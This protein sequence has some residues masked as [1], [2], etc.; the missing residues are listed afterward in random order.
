[1]EK[2]RSGLI[3][4]AGQTTDCEFKV[5]IQF[6]L[7]ISKC[8]DENTFKLT[9][10]V[11]IRDPNLSHWKGNILRNLFSWKEFFKE[12]FLKTFNLASTATFVN[13]KVF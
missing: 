7:D 5:F 3:N 2:C 10:T 4:A 8:F 12:N 9:E 1:M 6:I 13:I 11:A